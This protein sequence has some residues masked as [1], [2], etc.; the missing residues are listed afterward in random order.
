MSLE[1]MQ[2]QTWLNSH[3]AS[4]KVDGAAGPKTRAAI[5][6]VFR[7]VD[8]PAV[9]PAEIRMFGDRLGGDAARMR[10]VAEVEAPRGG[11][12][13]SGLMTCLY[14]RHYLWRRI[15]IKVPFL[16][17]PKP[18]GYTIDIDDDGI[19]DSWEKVADAACRF[20]AA[21]AFE[22]ASWGK[23]QIM[24]AW[25]QRLG[26]KSAL[27]FVWGM[28]RAEVAHYE[29]LCRYIERFDLSAAFRAISAD[30]EDCRAFAKGYN[31]STYWK[32]AYHER[33]AAAFRRFAR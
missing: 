31:G 15:A 17:D 28:S 19:N 14:E 21:K 10:A 6:D 18:G 29:A 33:I 7:N 23:F 2:L 9:T 26:Y 20:G 22:C 12:D 3:G 24:G 11:W 25:W 27:D 1:A 4:L 8:A 32:H 5:F 30:P 16:A 13:A